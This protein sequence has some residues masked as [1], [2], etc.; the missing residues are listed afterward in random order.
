MALYHEPMYPSSTGPTSTASPTASGVTCVSGGSAARGGAKLPG[1]PSPTKNQ[2][3]SCCCSSTVNVFAIEAAACT[4]VS[5][6]VGEPNGPSACSGSTGE[7][8][9]CFSTSHTEDSSERSSSNV[10][11]PFPALLR[12]PHRAKPGDWRVHFEIEGSAL[13]M[14]QLLRT[15]VRWQPCALKHDTHP[16]RMNSVAHERLNLLARPDAAQPAFGRCRRSRSHRS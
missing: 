4:T 10:E 13:H 3:P 15:V 5:S 11:P 1:R 9:N 16:T 8:S 12:L 2:S 14:Q 7:K 6:V